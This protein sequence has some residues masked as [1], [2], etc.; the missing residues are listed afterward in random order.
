MAIR[1][2]PAVLLAAAGLVGAFTSVAADETKDPLSAVVEAAGEEA[3]DAALSHIVC[4]EVDDADFR[5]AEDLPGAGLI[6]AVLRKFDKDGDGAV[7]A[8]ERAAAK[9]KVH[10]E[11]RRK[12][13]EPILAQADE[14][15]DGE[16]SEAEEGKLK[17]KL[18]AF[19]ARYENARQQ[20]KARFD[21]DGDG[22]LSKAERDAL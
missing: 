8:E 12:L 1:I 20:A 2:G 6:N 7:S 11:V 4:E 19:R 13:E 5:V 22:K 14:N 16:L 3:A 15:G 10:D 17:D 21:A 9:D 18:A